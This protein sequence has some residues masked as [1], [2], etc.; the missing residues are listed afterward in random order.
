MIVKMK[1]IISD[2]KQKEIFI[3]IFHILKNCSS[4]ANITINKEFFYIQGMDKSHICLYDLKIEKNWFSSYDLKDE[5]KI[6]LDTNIF[7]SI[8]SNKSENQD[9]V[10]YLEKEDSDVLCIQFILTTSFTKNK[11][12]KGDFKKSFKISLLDYDYEEMFIPIVEY[13]ADFSISSKQITEVLSEL[14]NFGSDV[15][16]KCQENSINLN[17][18]GLNGEM[19]V[20]IDIN[21]VE[22]YSIVENEIIKLTYSLNYLYKMCISNKI[23]NIIDFNISNEC[24]MKIFYS[25]GD[26][27]YLSFYIAP[28]IND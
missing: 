16:I 17:T 26:N 15:I 19:N 3:S 9:L 28:K 23:S 18:S 24:P 7:Y 22:S 11:I 6:C 20:E 10:I 4:H 25:L 21:D 8:I 14:S 13:D 1:I 12:I 5:I 27:S 2:K